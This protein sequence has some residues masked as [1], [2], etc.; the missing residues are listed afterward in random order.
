[1]NPRA[2]L[3]GLDGA[4]W[5]V[6]DENAI[7]DRAS[8]EDATRARA[9]D[10]RTLQGVLLDLPGDQRMV[11]ELGYFAGYSCSE[12][13]TQLSIPLGTVKSRMSR[14]IIALRERF[15]ERQGSRP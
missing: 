14:A 9:R 8:N 13:A 12:I 4:T 10:Q 7:H 1:M 5:T 6:L 2:V 3:I 15:E 11:L